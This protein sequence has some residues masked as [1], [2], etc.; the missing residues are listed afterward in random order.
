MLLKRFYDEPLAQASY[1]IGCAATGEALVVDAHRDVDEYLRA[2]EQ[3][4]L[5]I[6]H[7]TE[8][9]IHADFVSG[10]RE[11]AQRAG[12]RLYLSAEGGHEWQY[13]FATGDRA[14]LLHDGDTF[15]VGNV[16]I[17]ALH[18]PG[19]TPE[20]LCFVITDT[21]ATSQP[22]GV[23]TGDFI[24]AGDVGRPDLLEKVARAAGTMELGARALFRSLQK[25]KRLPDYFQLWPGHGAGSACGKSLGAIPSTTLGYEKV[26]NWGLA[27]QSEDT[28]VNAV[29]SGQP[30][31]PVYFAQMKRINRE[32]PSLLHG[33][34]RPERLAE[35]RLSTLI[36]QHATI[37]DTRPA[38]EFAAAH[39][40]GALN[41]PFNKSFTTWA[42]WLL[43]YDA[44]F[45]LI[46]DDDALADIDD[47][48]RSLQKI[49]LDAI[50]GYFST[51][52]IEAY[53][54]E[55]RPLARIPQ[56][57]ADVLAQRMVS[58]DVAVVDVRGWNEW[59]AGHIPSVPNIPLGY[60]V[61]HLPELPT[62]RSLV[63]QCASGARS[64]IAVSLLRARG[65]TNVVNL[66]GGFDAWERE[67]HPVEQGTYHST[68]RQPAGASA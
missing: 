25:F 64:A 47:I 37:V 16:R 21:A 4:G 23:L 1:L 36:E 13:A 43:K 41:L 3:E 28:F 17:E 2:A 39:V 19:H 58:G 60:L 45:Y 62:D 11:L 67:G 6:T 50:A 34:R 10:S 68:R 9:H 46:V 63:V 56:I 8:T 24:F 54:G 40:P 31:P 15:M 51:K 55:G 29:L 26:V 7:V 22:M 5:R 20:H 57:D 33:E 18:T 12:A 61:D 42:G 52:V 32:G 35:A 27:D 65:F 53:A 44:P 14:T 30:E 59:L 66:S 38:I 48:V 49:G